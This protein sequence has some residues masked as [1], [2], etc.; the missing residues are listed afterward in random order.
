M[1]EETRKLYGSPLGGNNPNQGE[2]MNTLTDIQIFQAHF[3][4][5]WGLAQK[6]DASYGKE[7][8]A[9]LRECIPVVERLAN[10]KGTAVTTNYG[11]GYGATRQ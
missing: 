5:L 3:D 6:L 8:V 10:A 4:V 11:G 9:K 1:G 2:K 7:I